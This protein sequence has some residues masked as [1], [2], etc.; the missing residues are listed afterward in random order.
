MLETGRMKICHASAFNFIPHFIISV[1]ELF[2]IVVLR[3]IT[4]VFVDEFFLGVPMI[5]P[6]KEVWVETTSDQGK[7]YYYHSK[8]RQSIWKRPNEENIQ[9]ITQ[10]E[11]NTDVFNFCI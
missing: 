7:M 10:G 4:P 11:V 2:L 3:F 6:T 9:I 5:D 1:V 8:T